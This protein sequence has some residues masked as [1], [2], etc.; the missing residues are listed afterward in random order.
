[1]DS[2]CTLGDTQVLDPIVRRCMEEVF[3]QTRVYISHH[4]VLMEGIK[5]FDIKTVLDRLPEI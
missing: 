5:I 4:E 1:M 3:D 2:K